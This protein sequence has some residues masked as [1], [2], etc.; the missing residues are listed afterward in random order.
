LTLE[1]ASEYLIVAFWN[2]FRQPKPTAAT[3]IT[4]RGVRRILADPGSGAF[5][6]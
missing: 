2:C 3:T 5:L 4:T 1:P 6:T